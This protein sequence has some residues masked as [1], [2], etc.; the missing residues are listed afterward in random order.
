VVPMDGATQDLFT[1]FT[2]LKEKNRDLKL[3]IAIGGWAFND[4]F[5]STQ[6][7]FHDLVSNAENRSKFII[8]LVAFLRYYAFDGVDFDW[9]S[10]RNR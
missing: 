6:A 1:K 2:G 3:M 8:N 9:V 10:C 7:V 5:T 4:N